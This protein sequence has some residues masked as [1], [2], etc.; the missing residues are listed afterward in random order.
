MTL[1][2]YVY[3]NVLIHASYSILEKYDEVDTN[4]QELFK[5][6]DALDL[7]GI[8]STQDIRANEVVSLDLA[9]LKTKK[10][11]QQLIK[12]I[13]REKERKR[14]FQNKLREVQCEEIQFYPK[15]EDFKSEDVFSLDEY[16][17]K[18]SILSVLERN[19]VLEN[20]E[21]AKEAKTTGI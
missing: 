13:L 17:P 11:S 10:R 14:T 3:L 18:R 9:D 12:A 7:S 6:L 2:I 4:L 20:I 15:K 19:D 16:A 5:L 8:L 1:I 21:N